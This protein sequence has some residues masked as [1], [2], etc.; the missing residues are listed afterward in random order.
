M[1]PLPR[2]RPLSLTHKHAIR[3]AELKTAATLGGRAG[4]S[5]LMPDTCGIWSG[6]AQMLQE[7]LMGRAALCGKC[8][9]TSLTTSASW[10]NILQGF[11]SS[12]SAP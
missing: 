10:K 5:S 8:P 1:I 11:P 2:H 9:Q 4:L 6:W 7:H 3:S 12:V